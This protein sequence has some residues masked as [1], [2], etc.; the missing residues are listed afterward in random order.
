MSFDRAQAAHDNATQPEYELYPCRCDHEK[1][2]HW[3]DD[4][5]EEYGCEDCDCDEF[6]EYG[7]AERDDDL[8][9]DAADAANDDYRSGG[10]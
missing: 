9:W 7:P 5:N 1:D 10:F 6:S 2:R 4:A 8:R 3:D